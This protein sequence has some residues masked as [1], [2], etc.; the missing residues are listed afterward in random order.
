MASHAY[1]P[2]AVSYDLTAVKALADA[3]DLG[4]LLVTTAHTAD[5]D[6]QDVAD[7]SADEVSVGGY[8]RVTA[9]AAG[10]VTYDAANNRAYLPLTDQIFSSLAAGETIQAATVYD[11]VDAA[12]ADKDLLFNVELAVAIPTSGG[13]VTIDFAAETVRVAL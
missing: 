4:C 6:D 13:D 3:T 12:D 8:A 7:V 10:A 5:P 2:F 11:D 1:Q 9:L